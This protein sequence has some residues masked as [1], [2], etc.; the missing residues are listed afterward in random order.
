MES[1]YNF[2]RVPCSWGSSNKA[3]R[4][5]LEQFCS[6]FEASLHRW[7]ENE[8]SSRVFVLLVSNATPR[9]CSRRDRS[10]SSVLR[11]EDTRTLYSFP[12]SVQPWFKGSRIVES[13]YLAIF[14]GLG[15]CMVAQIKRKPVFTAR[16]WH[17]R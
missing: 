8:S 7:S 3:V 13:I 4:W 5:F 17:F 12:F 9:C 16:G 10:S 15:I 14:D 11:N 2:A 1:E 6:L